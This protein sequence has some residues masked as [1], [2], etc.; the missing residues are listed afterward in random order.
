[1][2]GQS[3]ASIIQPLRH[4][5]AAAR[6][7]LFLPPRAGLLPPIICYSRAV[8]LSILSASIFLSFQ[9]LYSAR[10]ALTCRSK[11]P[12]RT[13]IPS[14]PA[15]GI[16]DGTGLSSASRRDRRCRMFPRGRRAFRV[17]CDAG[18]LCPMAMATGR[19]P[20]SK[21]LPSARRK[22]PPAGK[23][24]AYGG[25]VTGVFRYSDDALPCLRPITV[26]PRQR[27]HGN[28]DRAGMG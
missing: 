6:L 15:L 17:F 8:N 10:N 5:V 1:M 3:P 18:F 26:S 28:E 4:G 24:H 12:P 23:G 9:V 14:R 7:F 16:V 20:W 2:P 13:E 21:R 27:R 19:G 11:V 22:T 25:E